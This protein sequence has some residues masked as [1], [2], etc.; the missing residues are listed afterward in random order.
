M[1]QKALSEIDIIGKGRFRGLF[2]RLESL[3]PESE[4]VSMSYDLLDNLILNIII[5]YYNR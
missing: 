1:N 4:L 2:G 3:F 5:N